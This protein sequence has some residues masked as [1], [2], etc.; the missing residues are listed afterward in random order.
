LANR[1]DYLYDE[2]GTPYGGVYRSPATST[3][4]TYFTT[5]T[6]ARGD[7]CE[8]LDANG[9]AFAAYH[10]DAWGL[11]QGAGNY[12]T[13]IWTAST[14]LVS[15]TL[16]GQIA[17]R[18]V[19]RYA[20]YAYDSQSSLYYCSARYYDPVTRQWTTAD[21]AKADGEES[22]YQYCA[23]DPVVGTDH[24][25]QRLD[26][27]AGSGSYTPKP[28]YV[29]RPV[30]YTPHRYYVRIYYPPVMRERIMKKCHPVFH[31]SKKP[32]K[33]NAPKRSW[34]S[35]I[36]RNLEEANKKLSH[37]PVAMALTMIAMGA[38]EDGD[39]GMVGGAPMKITLPSA[40]GALA[41]VPAENAASIG[42]RAGDLA[43]TPAGRPYTWHYLTET[44]PFRNMPGSV[45]DETI[46]NATEVVNK[47][48]R[49]VY[50]DAKNDV[51]VVKSNTTGRIMSVRRGYG[52]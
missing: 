3:S 12:A 38:L 11:P 33:P 34:L 21:S 47:G 4:P 44:G 40:D 22:A 50:Y 6:N 20:T 35:Q 32:P 37:D 27:S 48:D 14:S 45:A 7:V 29:P 31:K 9:N 51:T 1:V 18:Q 52:K 19:L 8:L 16:A 49:N 5:I 30:Y 36:R 13:G 43:T 15:S 46:D 42:E 17:G 2:E 41:D 23:G 39:G 28:K 26:W 24:S 25:G 10:Y